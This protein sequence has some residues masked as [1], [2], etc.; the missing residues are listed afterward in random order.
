MQTMLKSMRAASFGDPLFG[1]SDQ[2]EMYRGM[3]DQQLVHRDVE[4]QGYRPRRHARAPAR[5]RS[6]APSDR[7]STRAIPGMACTSPDAGVPV[8]EPLRGTDVTA[9]RL[10]DVWPMWPHAERREELGTSRPRRCSRAGGAG[11]RLGRAR[12]CS[13]ADGSSSH[14][15]FGIKAGAAGAVPLSPSRHSSSRTVR[16][17][18]NAA[19][20]FRA[21]PTSRR[22][23]TITP[24]C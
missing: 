13:A 17:R 18:R 5:R 22:R 10:G 14:N 8:P 20:R 23:S 9:D 16:A 3:L 11:D 21:Y 7:L 4:R 1:D 6:T 24:R 19:R 12:A 2:H 15:L